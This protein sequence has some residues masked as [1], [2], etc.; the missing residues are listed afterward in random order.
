MKF[1]LNVLDDGTG[2]DTA[3][4]Q[5]AIDAFNDELRA[6]GQLILAQ[7]LHSPDRSAVF[8]RRGERALATSGPFVESAEYIAGFWV[9]EAPDEQSARE[10]A[11]RASQACNRRIELRF[12]H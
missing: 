11:A 4:E 9:L 10:L 12:M 5:D 3:A 7:G 6:S 2:P 1:I 8:D